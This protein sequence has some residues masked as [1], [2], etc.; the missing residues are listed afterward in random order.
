MVVSFLSPCLILNYDGATDIAAY[1]YRCSTQNKLKTDL[2]A[3]E[4]QEK[5]SVHQQGLPEAKGQVKVDG[6][7]EAGHSIDIVRKL[8]QKMKNI[9]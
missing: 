1:L 6:P 9:V 7:Q 8:A 4:V 2:K 3:I 5:I